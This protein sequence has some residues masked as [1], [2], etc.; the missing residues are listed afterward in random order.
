[1]QTFAVARYRFCGVVIQIA[2]LIT[3]KTIKKTLIFLRKTVD[4]A[5]L[6]W[7][8]TKAALNGSEVEDLPH[9]Y[10]SET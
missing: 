5:V 6:T 8:T 1:M 2:L 3:A 4:I 10:E 7:Y 9:T